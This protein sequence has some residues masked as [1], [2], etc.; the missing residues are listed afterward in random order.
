M[1]VYLTLLL[2][3]ARVEFFVLNSAF[4]KAFTALASQQTVVKTAYFVAAHRTQIVEAQ[5]NVQGHVRRVDV[6]HTDRMYVT[7]YKS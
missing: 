4:K 6:Q 7:I 2:V 5:L 1:F 3:D